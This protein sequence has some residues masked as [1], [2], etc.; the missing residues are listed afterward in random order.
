MLAAL[1]ALVLLA[2]PSDTVPGTIRGSVQ[3]EP[4]GVP[5]VFAVVRVEAGG[6]VLDTVT[7][8]AGGYRLGRIPAGRSLL[9]VR[10]LDHAP[11]ELEVLVPAGGELSLDF[12]LKPRPI[13]LATVEVQ[14]VPPGGAGDTAVASHGEMAM[15]SSRALEAG[16]A[17]AGAGLGQ[18]HD[19][20]GAGGGEGQDPNDILYVRGSSADL[21]LVLLDGAPVYA[22]FHMGG[23]I[24]T[25]DPEALGSARLYLGGAPARYDGGLSYVLD[26][27]TRAGREEHPRVA[28]A[29]DLLSA[30][31]LTEGPLPGGATFLVSGRGVHGGAVARLEGEPFPYGYAEGLTRLDVPLRAD[32]ELGFTAY[33][34]REEVRV[35]SLSARD[36]VAHWGNAAGSL[37]WRGP[38]LGARAEATAALTGFRARLPWRSANRAMAVEAAIGRARGAL[39]LSRAAWGAQLRYGLSYDR[40]WV[41]HEA[42]LREV[43]G[44][45]IRLASDSRGDAGGVYV[46]AA[47][48]A[49]PRLA[50][51]A[52]MRG[53]IFSVGT[54]LSL[55]PRLS[56]TWLMGEGAALT[57]AGGRYHQYVR[58]AGSAPSAAQ[59]EVSFGDSLG[60]GTRLAVSRATHAALALD[61]QLGGDLRLGL[62]GYF[63]HFEGLP[64]GD[65]T[66]SY[67]S[68][69]DVW[70]R[71]VA[72]PVSGWLGYSLG[73]SWSEDEGDAWQ[74]RRFSG[75]H[76]LSAGM[77]GEIGRHGRFGV[78]MAYGAGLPYTA[79]YGSSA[80]SDPN[81]VGLTTG[82]VASPRGLDG[83]AEDDGAPLSGTPRDPYLRVDAEISRTWTPRWGA[84]R[85]ELTP[86]LR[87]LNALDRR[88]ALFYRY[89]G[90]GE[91]RSLA[92]LPFLPVVGVSFRF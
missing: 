73:W 86:Y 90:S 80:P 34:N 8:S 28:G 91:T 41:E 9:R 54:A 15:V 61:Q 37:R 74:T 59:G 71:R 60:V 22:P 3:S 18:G 87:V 57:L 88:D 46:D 31:L 20:P 10:H 1:A 4:T 36:P 78:R 35:D 29:V 69:V 58:Q 19:G 84:R 67:H 26:M 72:G 32:S 14:T 27:R 13:A 42:G 77:A 6:R 5:L 12:A 30:R 53:D 48:Q 49:A 24:H 52:G 25:F 38:L 75:R 21:K 70:A 89:D 43:E 66:R 65:P 81:A 55:S 7:D 17:V 47:W 82:S 23:L 63:K 33:V 64:P 85:A 76:L 50:V 39:D 11:L 56:A 44:E 51:R 45:P 83:R 40:I 2:A 79:L 16:A 68:G 62:E 92:T